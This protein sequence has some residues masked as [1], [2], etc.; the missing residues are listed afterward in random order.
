[1][2]GSRIR[3][4]A[5]SGLGLIAAVALA[6]ALFTLATLVPLLLGAEGSHMAGDAKLGILVA[7]FPL[8]VLAIVFFGLARATEQS[9]RAIRR[10]LAGGFLASVGVLLAG[11][12]GFLLP[13]PPP[14]AAIPAD[15]Q[16]V[17]VSV[18]DGVVTVAPSTVT[19]GT[20]WVLFDPSARNVA[21]VG[22]SEGP[23]SAGSL[24]PE[25]LSDAEIAAIAAGDRYHTYTVAGFGEVAKLTVAA[26]KYVFELDDPAQMR[27]GQPL[28]PLS[29][30]VLEVAPPP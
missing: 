23:Q 9:S 30:G 10:V 20:I 14:T 1:M 4:F 12:V 25:P 19:A 5:S 15:A 26:G 17:R 16:R 28:P 6:G 11:T 13:V 29:I 22:K 27:T 21:F 7:T 2:A 3:R 24:G 8:T 18:S